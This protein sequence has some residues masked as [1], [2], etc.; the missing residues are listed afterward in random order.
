MKLPIL[1]F[2]TFLTT[3]ALAQEATPALKKEAFK[4][5]GSS[6]DKRPGGV[7]VPNAVGGTTAPTHVTTTPGPGGIAL[8]PDWDKHVTQSSGGYSMTMDDLAAL[9]ANYGKPDRDVAAHPEVVVFEGPVMDSVRDSCRIMYLTPLAEA[10]KALFKLGAGQVAHSDAVLPGFPEGL[11][12]HQYGIDVQVPQGP[13]YNQ[14]TL[15]TDSAQRVVALQMKDAR[16]NWHPV[17]WTVVPRDW[18]T[19]DFVNMRTRGAKQAIQIR[20][21]DRREKE[22]QIIVNIAFG[23]LPPNLVPP[24]PWARTSGALSE[25]STWCLPEPLIKLAL[26][27]LSQRAAR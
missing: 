12:L 17:P 8:K 2:V 25:T 10:E 6:L 13:H 5:F 9:L 14:L 7:T 24:P 11:A 1:S 27:C 16:Q 20:L 26:Y 23:G 15:V 4:G 21:L 22:H 19:Y 18:H 3:A